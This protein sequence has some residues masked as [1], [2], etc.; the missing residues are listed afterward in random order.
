MMAFICVFAASRME[1]RPALALPSRSGARNAQGMV[2][3]GENQVATIITGVGPR[4]AELKAWAAFGLSAQEPVSPGMPPKP[5]AVLVIGLCGGLTSAIQPERLVLYDQCFLA[6]PGGPLPCSKPMTEAIAGI[7]QKRSIS[8]DR[9]AGVT[10]PRM[11]SGK[12]ERQALAR[13]G[14][15]VV[16]METYAI[17]AAAARAG[18]PAAVLRVVSD[19]LDSGMPDFNPA[20]DAQGGLAMRR[21]ALIAFRSPRWTWRLAFA[22]R[23]A[24]RRLAPAVQ[25]ILPSLCF[26]NLQH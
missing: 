22:S 15:D 12:N 19:S 3:R 25:A 1:A 24:M 10:S 21:A 14:A 8:F 6:G 9:A 16:D 23:R 7:L 2:S 20:F 17:L 13:L 5:D 26:S 11:A 18:V 4:N